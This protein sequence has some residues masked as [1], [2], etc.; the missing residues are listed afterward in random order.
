VGIFVSA[1]LLNKARILEAELSQK[2]A[3]V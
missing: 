3:Y 2:L 1:S